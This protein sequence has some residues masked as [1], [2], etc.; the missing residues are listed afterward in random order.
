MRRVLRRDEGIGLGPLD[1]TFGGHIRRLGTVLTVICSAETEIGK[2]GVF[3]AEPV[4]VE[5][6]GVVRGC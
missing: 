1:F 5:L 2:T 3:P 4:T 6:N